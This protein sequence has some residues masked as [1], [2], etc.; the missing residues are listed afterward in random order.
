MDQHVKGSRNIVAGRDI[1]LVSPRKM[2]S[3]LARVVPAITQSFAEGAESAL[4]RPLIEIEE[5]LRLTRVVAYENWVKRY[6]RYGGVLE[7]AYVQFEKANPGTREKLTRSIIDEW[8][9]EEAGRKVSG[10]DISADTLLDGVIGRIKSIVGN[11]ES[12]VDTEEI[13]PAVSLVVCAEFVSCQI[14][15]IVSSD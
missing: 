10:Q 2:S 8:L 15:P 11:S 1:N 6:C 4:M 14:P 12:G 5:K 3:L 13:H 7:R 9:L